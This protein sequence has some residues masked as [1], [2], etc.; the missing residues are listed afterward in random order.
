[1]GS[2]EQAELSSATTEGTRARAGAVGTLDRAAKRLGD[3]VLALL[4]MV[5]LSPVLVA[6][7]VAIRVESRGPLFYRAPR[8]GRGGR[9]LRIVKFRKMVDGASGQAL[10][11]DVD[12]RFTRIGRFLA[13]TKL[14]ELPQLWNVLRGDMSLVG[15][16]PEDPEFVTMH[17][18]AYREILT[19]RPGI[20]GLCQ[21]AFAK[22]T[23]ILD[24]DDR[25][26]H[27]VGRILPQKVALDVLYARSRTF[28]GDLKIMLW[29]ILPLI[30]RRDVA[31]KR[32]TGELSIRTRH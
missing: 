8:I 18:D 28:G 10:T 5:V 4:L 21:L 17:A 32:E 27:Y 25:L 24:P 30:L 13:R 20:T 11:G 22:E 19:V 31:V 23:E 6:C 3:V 29:T 15:P 12:E 14:D 26:G 16:R 2:F 9:H 7:A 1:V